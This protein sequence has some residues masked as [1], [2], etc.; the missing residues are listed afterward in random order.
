MKAFSKRVA[1]S[2]ILTGSLCWTK[3]THGRGRSEEPAEA[4]AVR[5]ARDEGRLE[6]GGALLPGERIL[7]TLKVGGPQVGSE[8]ERRERTELA[9]TATES[10]GE[11]GICRIRTSKTSGNRVSN[12]DV[13]KMVKD[14]KEGIEMI[15]KG[16]TLCRGTWREEMMS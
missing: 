1:S 5:Q 6:A 11:A 8:G 12:R 15:T 2:H 10:V 16:C 7:D 3:P 13:F 4:T 14:L 9:V